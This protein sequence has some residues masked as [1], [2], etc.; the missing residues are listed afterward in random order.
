MASTDDLTSYIDAEPTPEGATRIGIAHGSIQGLGS[1]GEAKNYVSP[2]RA[3]SAG[4]AYLALG[5]WHR[6]LV[7]WVE[8]AKPID[9]GRLMII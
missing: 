1:E 8:L 5:D 6:Q 9:I 2:N 3:D 4:L 7:G